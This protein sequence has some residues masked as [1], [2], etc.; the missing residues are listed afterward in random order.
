MHL[1]FFEHMAL[2]ESMMARLCSCVE[3]AYLHKGMFVHLMMAGSE[4]MQQVKKLY[5]FIL[6]QGQ[7][8]NGS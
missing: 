5:C 6:K 1:F 8:L 4:D 7:K 2:M 3:H